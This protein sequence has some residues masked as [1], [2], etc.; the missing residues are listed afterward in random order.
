[1]SQQ[2]VWLPQTT[3]AEPVGRAFGERVQVHSSPMSM[4][5]K[6]SA[7]QGGNKINCQGYGNTFMY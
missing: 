7:Q 3:I 1:M 2:A 6:E 4:V 5:F